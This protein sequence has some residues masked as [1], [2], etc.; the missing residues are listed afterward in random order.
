MIMPKFLGRGF[1]VDVGDDDVALVVE[2][3]G[4]PFWD[5]VSKRAMQINSPRIQNPNCSEEG[6]TYTP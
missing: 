5:I 4:M 2:G 6:S 1:G 3:R